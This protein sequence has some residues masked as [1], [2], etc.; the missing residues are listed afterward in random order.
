MNDNE[1]YNEDVVFGSI[2]EDGV[3]CLHDLRN[4]NIHR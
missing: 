3:F 4:G 1:D 2:Y